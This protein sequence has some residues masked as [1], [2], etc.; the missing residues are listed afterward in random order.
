[1]NDFREYFRN[2]VWRG[3]WLDD[4]LQESYRCGEPGSVCR[5]WK[6]NANADFHTIK[7]H[8]SLKIS[9]VHPRTRRTAQEAAR[10]RKNSLDGAKKGTHA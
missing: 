9:S 1:M 2:S 7:L 3:L 6:V 10:A 4:V 8:D 5:D